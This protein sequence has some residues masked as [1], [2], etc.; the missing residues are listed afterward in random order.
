MLDSEAIMQGLISC[1]VNAVLHGHQH[2]P[3]LSKISR[4]IP[5]GVA[6]TEDGLDG[7][8]NII[9]GGSAG[10]SQGELNSIGRNTYN[11]LWLE[12]ETNTEAR[13]DQEKKVKLRVK[14]RVRNSDGVGYSTGLDRE[15]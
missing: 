15:F 12:G 3:Y 8:L 2:Q 7:E 11:L 5:K 14:L 10:V 1:G 4:F 9:G 6:G 13:A